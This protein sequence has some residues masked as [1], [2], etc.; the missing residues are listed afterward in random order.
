MRKYKLELLIK[1]P[2]LKLFKPTEVFA[3]IETYK[4]LHD[5]TYGN[6]GGDIMVSQRTVASFYKFEEAERLL[7]RLI[8][9]NGQEL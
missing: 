5:P 6:G 9:I 3:V 1:R 7:D 8:E 4:Y 2:I